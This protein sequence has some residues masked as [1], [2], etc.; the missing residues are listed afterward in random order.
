MVRRP[1]DGPPALPAL[2]PVQAQ[3][4]V[5]RDDFGILGLLEETLAD[6]ASNEEDEVAT[7]LATSV[8]ASVRDSIRATDGTD[9]IA[10]TTA[11]DADLSLRSADPLDPQH[12]RLHEFLVDQRPSR[13]NCLTTSSTRS[14]ASLR[15]SHRIPSL[16]GSTNTSSTRITPP[17]LAST[18]RRGRTAPSQ[19]ICSLR[20]GR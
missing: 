7:D 13:V 20:W 14:S 5:S 1:A 17:K 12:L 8:M 16:S 11:L 3:A 10:G 4:T 19:G 6:V 2:Q 15:T 9:P 18:T